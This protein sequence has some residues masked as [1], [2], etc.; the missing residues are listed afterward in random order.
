MSTTTATRTTVDI[1]LEGLLQML[2]ATA[3]RWTIE[4]WASHLSVSR[5]AIHTANSFV[6]HE[7]EFGPES[8]VLWAAAFVV[9]IARIQDQTGCIA[10]DAAALIFERRAARAAKAD[11]ARLAA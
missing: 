3:A 11:P 10:G 9:T 5:H 2:T 8:S 7:A 6:K 1:V 4:G